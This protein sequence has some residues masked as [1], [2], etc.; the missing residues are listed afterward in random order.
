MAVVEFGVFG[1]SKSS[2]NKSWSTKETNNGRCNLG[3][4]SHTRVVHLLSA[5][6]GMY[7]T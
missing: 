1:V 3:I 4:A 2:A 7:V 6:Y 5:K